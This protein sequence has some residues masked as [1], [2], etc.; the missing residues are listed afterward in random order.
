MSSVSTVAG[1]KRSPVATVGESSSSSIPD[2]VRESLD[3]RASHY[4]FHHSP[5]SAVANGLRATEHASGGATAWTTPR[6]TPPELLT[7][8]QVCANFAGMLAFLVSLY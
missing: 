6:T 1:E 7:L 5:P 4:L 2:G 8:I 3:Q